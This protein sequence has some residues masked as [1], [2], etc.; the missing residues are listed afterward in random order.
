MAATHEKTITAA[1]AMFTAGYSTGTSYTTSSDLTIYIPETTSRAFK[2]VKLVL[3]GHDTV[4]TPGADLAAWSVRASCNSGTN[5]TTVTQSSTWADTGETI[6]FRIEADVT[7]EF[8]NRFGSSSSGTCRVGWYI[9]YSSA[10]TVNNIAVSL[11]ITYEYDATAHTS[12]RIK[13][14]WIP[15]ESA[16]GQQGTSLTEIGTNQV[17]DLSTF[18]PE[19]SK[20]FRQ[21]YFDL[22]ASTLPSGTT[23]NALCLALDSEAET[24]LGTVEFAPQSNFPFRALWIRDDMTTNATHALKARHNAGSGSYYAQLGGMLAATYEYDPASATNIK[25]IRIPVP[26]TGFLNT[27]SFPA[28]VQVKFMVNEPGTITLKQSALVLCACTTTTNDTLSVKVGSQS[29]RAYTPSSQSDSGSPMFVVHRID[30]GGAQGAGMTLAA[31]ENTVDIQMYC[32]STRSIG[33]IYGYL[34]INYTSGVDSQDEA[35]HAHTTMWH[36]AA[37]NRARANNLQVTYAVTPKITPSNYYLIGAGLEILCTAATPN[38]LSTIEC[39]VSRET[40]DSPA[41]GLQVLS[42]GMG[43]GASGEMQWLFM[44]ASG[45]PFFQRYPGDPDTTRLNIETTRTVSSIHAFSVQLGA[46]LYVTASSLTYNVTG[47]VSN[48]T[49]DGSGI[50]VYVHRADTNEYLGSATTSAGGSYTFTWYEDVISKFAH[51]RVSSTLMGRSDNGT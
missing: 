15:I 5:Y 30:S 29:V 13:T 10:S 40:G 32:S 21:V 7:S 22:M 45:T 18:L 41:S 11:E 26:L 1:F 44:G 42:D 19:S 16:T 25:S 31:G 3:T 36:L 24:A 39:A 8:T 46:T 14:V 35:N 49:G 2:S 48:Y 47:T 20:T 6:P 17:P 27:S 23:D 12:T 38:G 37:T 28:N 51:A 50:T 33:M 43:S 4:A 34:V 9:N